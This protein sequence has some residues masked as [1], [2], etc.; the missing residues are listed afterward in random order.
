MSKLLVDVENCSSVPSLEQLKSYFLTHVFLNVLFYV[1]Q[2]HFLQTSLLVVR[3]LLYQSDLLYGLF[4]FIYPLPLQTFCTFQVLYF[5]WF[6]SIFSFSKSVRLRSRSETFYYL[7]MM[8]RRFNRIIKNHIIDSM[9]RPDWA[10]CFFKM[11]LRMNNIF[12]TYCF[13]IF[14]GAYFY[15]FI[16]F[17]N[18]TFV[19]LIYLVSWKFMWKGWSSCFG[20]FVCSS[21]PPKAKSPLLVANRRLCWWSVTN[22]L[23]KGK[24]SWKQCQKS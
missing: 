12:C 15:S 11:V 3:N 7:L 17:D 8:Y 19:L 4:Q 24:K 18:V 13:N 16:K 10:F 23:Q 21:F 9:C 1:H 6:E 22:K 20:I 5:S 14:S 2:F